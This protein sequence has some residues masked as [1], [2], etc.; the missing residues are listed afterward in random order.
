MMGLLD[1]AAQ[2]G[3]EVLWEQFMPAGWMG[4]YCWMTHS[5]TMLLGLG[6]IEQRSVLAHELGHATYRHRTDPQVARSNEWHADKWAAHQLIDKRDFFLASKD[7]PPLELLADRLDVT[8]H[9]ASV[10][11]RSFRAPGLFLEYQPVKMQL[12][13]P[14]YKET[15]ALAA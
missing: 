15:C 5:V 3:V 13:A 7:K 4:A 2:M 1:A 11:I 9:L 12:H 8:P 14:T 6:E 10:Y